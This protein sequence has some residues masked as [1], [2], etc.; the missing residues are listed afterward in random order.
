MER[1]RGG[2]CANGSQQKSYLKWDESVYSPTCLTES[3]FLTILIDAMEQHDV[4]GF[5]VPGAYLQTDIPAD[6]RILLR[7]IYEFVDIMCEVNLDY[8]PC[9]QYDNGIK[10]LYVK[11]MRSIYGCIES[12]LL[13]YNLYVNTLKY[14]GFIFNTYYRCMA[15]KIIYGNQCTIVWCVDDNN[16]LHVDPNVVTIILEENMKTF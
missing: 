7:I 14:L 1:S 16:L 4:A 9:V 15:N 12:D 11:V 5:D 10:V 2:A 13:W 6:K 8:K 3:L